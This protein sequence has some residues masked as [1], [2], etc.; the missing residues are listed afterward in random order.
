MDETQALLQNDPFDGLGDFE[1]APVAHKMWLERIV[2]ISL[3]YLSRSMPSFGG[4]VLA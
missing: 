1:I 3:W 2:S 4:P